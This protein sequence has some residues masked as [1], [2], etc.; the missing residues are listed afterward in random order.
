VVGLGNPEV[1]SLED[2]EWTGSSAAAQPS[3]NRA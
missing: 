3:Q 2:I 1:G